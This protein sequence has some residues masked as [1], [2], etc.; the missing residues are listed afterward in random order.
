[1]K[2]KVLEN[3]CFS[4]SPECSLLVLH[5]LDVIVAQGQVQE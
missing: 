1:M 4:L 5:C 2:S 3:T